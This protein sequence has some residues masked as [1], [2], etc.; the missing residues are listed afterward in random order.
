MAIRVDVALS[1]AAEQRAQVVVVVDVL[2]AST[3]IVAAIESGASSIRAV[4]AVEEARLLK[5]EQPGLLLC[6]EV[7]GLPPPGFDAGNSPVE[8]SNRDLN[9]HHLV[10]AT[11]NG[12]PLLNKHRAAH[13]LLVGCIRNASACARAALDAATESGSNILLA[14]AGSAHRG[15]PMA[16]D[17]FAAGLIIETMVH[18]Q[19][20]L[21]LGEG[22]RRALAVFYGHAGSAEKAFAASPHGRNLRQLGFLDDLA[23]CGQLDASTMVPMAALEG[24]HVVVRRGA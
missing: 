6:G 11:S 16:E 2:R 3:T 12:T 20:P 24:R 4:A 19:P 1:P 15:E 22:A 8:L 7:G 18:I 5:A 10:L 21:E 17:S 23:F 14:C 9:G 13:H